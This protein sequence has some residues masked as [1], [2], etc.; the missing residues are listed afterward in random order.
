M[1]LSNS[2]KLLSSLYNF[3]SF[4]DKKENVTDS[5]NPLF[6]REFLIDLFLIS[7]SDKTDLLEL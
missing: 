2:I 6:I 7:I 3:V 4:S 1:G 5:Y